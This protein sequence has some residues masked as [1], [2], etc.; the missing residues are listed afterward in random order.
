MLVRPTTWRHRTHDLQSPKETGTYKIKLDLTKR[1]REILR[2]ANEV[3]V[4]RNDTFVF[5]DFNCRLCLFRNGE[6]RYFDDL[7]DLERLNNKQRIESDYCPFYFPVYLGYLSTFNSGNSSVSSLSPYL[8]IGL[9][10]FNFNAL[11]GFEKQSV[12]A[13]VL[14]S[15]IWLDCVSLDHQVWIVFDFLFC[16]FLFHQNYIYCHIKYFICRVSLLLI[17]CQVQKPMKY[18]HVPPD[19]LPLSVSRT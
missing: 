14:C 8:L 4:T 19:F 9:F 12:I 17:K 6:Y 13:H 16:L 11:S 10:Q 2:K 5:A 7:I 18:P 1:R 3:L 15:A